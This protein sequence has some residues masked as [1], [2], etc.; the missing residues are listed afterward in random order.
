M[1]GSQASQPS[2]S[3]GDVERLYVALDQNQVEIV[4]F[5][6]NN[7]DVRVAAHATVFPEKPTE[8][9]TW[10]DFEDWFFQQRGL[11]ATPTPAPSALSPGAFVPGMGPGQP[12]QPTPQPTAQP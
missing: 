10:D 4:S 7:G 5:I 3:Y 2:V 11:L 6:L 1:G 9:V 12:G 8:G